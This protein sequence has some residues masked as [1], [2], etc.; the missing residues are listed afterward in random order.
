MAKNYHN[1]ALEASTPLQIRRSRMIR[2]RLIEPR[3]YSNIMSRGIPK[4]LLLASLEATPQESKVTHEDINIAR[5]VAWAIKPEIDA[6]IETRANDTQE[7]VDAKRAIIARHIVKI[8]AP[9][10][11]AASFAKG[12]ERSVGQLTA[13]READLERNYANAVTIAQ[14]G[15]VPSVE[16]LG[17]HRLRAEEPT[18]HEIGHQYEQIAA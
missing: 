13:I 4:T 18:Q 12:A 9:P 8:G 15:I 2:D 16:S 11:I 6:L 14:A 17:S 3:R 1:F 10:M 7:R 5:D